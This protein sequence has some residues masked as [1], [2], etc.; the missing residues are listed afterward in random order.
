MK[1]INMDILDIKRIAMLRGDPTRYDA[2]IAQM[3]AYAECLK[4]EGIIK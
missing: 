2:T 1:A 3:M 4:R